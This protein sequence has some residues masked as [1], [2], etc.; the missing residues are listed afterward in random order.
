MVHWKKEN[1]EQET[2][3]I[4]PDVYLKKKDDAST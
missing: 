4:L 2:L 1:T 3:I